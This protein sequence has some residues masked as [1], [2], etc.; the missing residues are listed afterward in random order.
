MRCHTTR[1]GGIV[2][3]G[4]GKSFD[5]A[6]REPFR[7]A[8]LT[9]ASEVTLSKFDEATGTAVEFKGPRGAKVGYDGPHESPG[10][11]HDMQHISWQA[12]GKRQAGGRQRANIPY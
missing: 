6:R 8:G 4:T 5:E 11:H 7:K 3:M 9:D 12:G 2:P 1:E 10:M